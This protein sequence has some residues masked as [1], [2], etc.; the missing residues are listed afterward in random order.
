MVGGPAPTTKKEFSKTSL[1]K[2]GILLKHGDGTQGLEELRWGCEEWLVL[3]YGVGEVKSK[4]GLQRDFD[5]LTRSP[6]L[7]EAQLQSS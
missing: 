3:P 1:G 2:K 4:G 6:K 5:V 7:P